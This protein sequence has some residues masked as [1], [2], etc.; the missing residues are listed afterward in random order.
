MIFFFNTL[1]E[2]PVVARWVLVTCISCQVMPYFL[3]LLR[4]L[5]Q[6][7]GDKSGMEELKKL[8]NKVKSIAKTTKTIV[9]SLRA[10]EKDLAVLRRAIEAQKSSRAPTYRRRTFKKPSETQDRVQKRSKPI[11]AQVNVLL[12]KN[13]ENVE[14]LAEK[15]EISDLRTEN[16]PS[17]TA[18]ISQLE[19]R[20]SEDEKE[21]E[22]GRMPKVGEIILLGVKDTFSTDKVVDVIPDVVEAVRKKTLIV[23]NTFGI[24]KR[25]IPRAVAAN[26]VILLKLP[27]LYEDHYRTKYYT[28]QPEGRFEVWKSYLWKT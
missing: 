20:S 22:I 15:P 3:A 24:K 1:L 6:I 8:A 26:S 16:L 23:R 12:A 17:E 9:K 10:I 14:K 11:A 7:I 4:P 28:N 19:P 18:E 21:I 27:K 13:I 25:I 5:I 2:S